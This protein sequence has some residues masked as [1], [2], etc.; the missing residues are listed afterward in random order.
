MTGSVIR[1]E[2]T[3]TRRSWAAGEGSGHEGHPGDTPWNPHVPGHVAAGRQGR[4]RPAD[5]GQRPTCASGL[6]PAHVCSPAPPSPRRR[7]G[8]LA[9]RV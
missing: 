6:D 1:A 9:Y 4:E 2:L 5:S 8:R 7:G 3:S